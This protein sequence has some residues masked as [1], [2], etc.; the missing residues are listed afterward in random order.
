MY[1]LPSGART[2]TTLLSE[3]YGIVPSW[4]QCEYQYHISALSQETDRR[5]T[6]KADVV[7]V[8]NPIQISIPQ[9]SVTG[10]RGASRHPGWKCESIA[11]QRM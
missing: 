5:T 3:F 2:P 11:S 4:V 1:V 6:F 9:A 10:T 8:L 7:T